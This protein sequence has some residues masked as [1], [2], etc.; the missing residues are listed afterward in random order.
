MSP[1]IIHFDIRPGKG[2]DIDLTQMFPL[3]DLHAIRHNRWWDFIDEI[4][5]SR[6]GLDFSLN[7]TISIERFRTI[8]T[9]DIALP[10]IIDVQ[11]WQQ[12]IL[13]RAPRPRIINLVLPLDIPYDVLDVR[14]YN[15]ISRTVLYPDLYTRRLPY[16]LMMR[17]TTKEA[18]RWTK[19]HRRSIAGIVFTLVVTM[20]PIL[21]FVKNSIENGYEKL[22]W[23]QNAS[24]ISEIRDIV[25]SAR[26]DFERANFLF[27][28]FS[29]IPSDT[30]DIA[31]RATKWWRSLTRGLSRILDTLP[32]QTGAVFSLDRSEILSP[33]FRPESID[34]FPLES[35]GIS[36]PT[37]WLAENQ[38]IL[39]GSFDDMYNAGEIYSQVH[40]WT[41]LSNKMHDVGVLL[42]RWMKYFSYAIEHKT[43][44]LTF[45]G[46]DEPIRYLILN[47]NRDEIRANGGFPWSVIALTLYKGNIL[48]MRRDDVYYYDWNLYPYKESPPP[49]LTLLTGN[50]GLRD[51]NY[52][53]DFLDTLEKANE[54]IERS[55]D[56]TITSAIA[57]H[58]GFIEDI[59]DKTWPVSIS[60]VTIPFE[61]TNFSLLMSTLV[62]NQF[63]REH[64][65]KDILFQFWKSLLTKVREQHLYESIFDIFEKNWNDWEILFASRDEG[66]DAIIA[67]FRR[68]LPWQ[69]EA[70]NNES[71]TMSNIGISSERST[72]YLLPPTSSSACSSNWVYPIFTS[73]SGNKSDR[74]ITRKYE[75]KTTKLQGCTYENI[76]TLSLSHTYKKSDTEKIRS[77][78]DILGIKDKAEREKLEFI[79]WNGKNRAFTRLYVPRSATLGF[80]GA[81]ITTTENE[82]AKVYSFMLETPVWGSTSKTLRYTVDIPNCESVAD[83]SVEWT[84]QP[85]LR[86]VE[87]R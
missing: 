21:F 17:R 77:Y 7:Q 28:P 57:I 68:E 66:M 87:V 24:N 53:P 23:L 69:C 33:E 1:K 14:A 75:S 15:T 44:L 56:S 47:Q 71:W 70:M 86:G 4:L 64:H 61:S 30:I 62:E 34:V 10:E 54:F 65:P 46:H 38:A 19:E 3:A 12:K 18:R 31:D 48:D 85:G 27:F 84:R 67:K 2:A 58:Q 72:S 32:S 59:L 6:I 13:K 73:V 60:G 51:V 74:Y 63:A 41:L 55:G 36:T 49:G 9:L 35:V 76:V 83:T 45:L 79:E 39:Q 26:D 50:Y 37:D 29:W 78:M 20:V 22:L 43:E 11:V 16:S 81:D 8:D 82:D 80:T 52:Y 40:T 5:P 42:S 25:D